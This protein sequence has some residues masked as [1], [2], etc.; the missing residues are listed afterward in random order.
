MI[1][2]LAIKNGYI[3]LDDEDIKYYLKNLE[4][5]IALFYAAIA[6]VWLFLS[7]LISGYFDNRADLLELKDRYY[8]QPLL[9]K[10]ISDKYREK[11]ATYLHEHYG[12]ILG[13]FFFG[14]LLGITPFIGYLLN[15]PL[16]ISHV[17]F[18]SA[19]LGYTSM[20]FDISVTLFIYYLV[21]VLLIGFVN[22]IVSFTLALKVSL[23]SRDTKFGNFFSFIKN[24]IIEICKKPHKLFFP[25]TYKNKK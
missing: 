25:F 11:F 23:L 10:L 15:L 6:G 4:P 14:I 2:Y 22:L 8:H 5:N 21:C 1:S 17:A 16:D 12:S 24:L 3:I 7:G 9:K 13:N 20:H 18:S 19:Y